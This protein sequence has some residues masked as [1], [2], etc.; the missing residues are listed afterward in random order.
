MSDYLVKI[1][2]NTIT[3]IKAF[4][5]NLIDFLCKKFKIKR[6]KIT[7][8]IILGLLITIGLLDVLWLIAPPTTQKPQIEEPLYKK[9]EIPRLVTHYQNILRKDNNNYQAHLELG[10]IFVF[11]DELENAK[12]EFFQAVEIA[13][14]KNYDAR[15]YLTQTYLALKV[16]EMAQEIIKEIPLNQL[17]EKLALKKIDTMYSI[18]NLYI[19]Q[20]KYQNAY[21]L[22]KTIC[23]E[24]EKRNQTEKRNQAQNLLVTSLM[25]IVDEAYYK[26][27]SPVKAFMYLDESLKTYE[28]PWAYTKLGFLFFEDTLLSAKYFDK[29]FSFGGNVVNYEVLESIFNDA[30]KI[31][32]EKR[33]NQGIEYYKGLIERLRKGNL[34]AKINTAIIIT[35][36]DG[37]LDKIDNNQY[38]PSVEVEICNKKQKKALRYLKLRTVFFDMN[39]KIIGHNDSLVLGC[40]EILSKGRKKTIAVKSNRAI[41]ENFKKNNICKVLFYISK[42][43]PDR[44]TYSNSKVFR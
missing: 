43:Q 30:I 44:W 1:F 12:V 8:L 14:Q 20:Q 7:L 19:E 2:D 18:A 28:N 22:L 25:N 37:F 33:D 9:E 36:A 42:E 24:Y 34:K 5:V 32:K 27:K 13:P 3:K 15:F 6:K 38:I 4:W 39:N 35:R 11:T 31:S 16:P 21:E 10:K 23:V 17:S 41:N 29:A 40:N 26:Y